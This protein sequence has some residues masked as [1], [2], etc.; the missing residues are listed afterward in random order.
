MN[1]E[2]QVILVG[3]L[4]RVDGKFDKS[5]A[6][7]AWGWIMVPHPRHEKYTKVSWWGVDLDASCLEWQ[8]R[9][10]RVSGGLY[11]VPRDSDDGFD[12]KVYAQSIE[13]AEPRARARR[14]NGSEERPVRARQVVRARPRPGRQW[15][16]DDHPPF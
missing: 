14:E 2:N 9:R 16:E 15:N 7:S 6:L 4:T 1:D 11:W 8:G 10:C 13:L 12:L 5:G 3:S